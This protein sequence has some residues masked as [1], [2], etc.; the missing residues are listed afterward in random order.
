MTGANRTIVAGKTAPI[1]KRTCNRVISPSAEK[2]GP[3]APKEKGGKTDGH[4]IGEAHPPQAKG[5][6]GCLRET[7]STPRI[8]KERLKVRFGTTITL[9]FRVDTTMYRFGLRKSRKKRA[10]Q[11]STWESRE[12]SAAEAARRAAELSYQVG[13]VGSSGCRLVTT[14]TL[15]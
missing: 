5:R 11:L 10:T 15:R 3:M 6:G 8:P 9:V 1:Q 4:P 2:K 14:L 7:D 13:T 12:W